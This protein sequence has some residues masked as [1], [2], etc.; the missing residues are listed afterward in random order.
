LLTHDSGFSCS[1]RSRCVVFARHGA[2]Q[3]LERAGCCAKRRSVH[4]SGCVDS[5]WYAY[6]VADKKIKSGY[7]KSHKTNLSGNDGR[8]TKFDNPRPGTYNCTSC[9]ECQVDYCHHLPGSETMTFT[10]AAGYF[11]CRVPILGLTS[12]AISRSTQSCCTAKPIYG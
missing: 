11:I 1:L 10:L 7:C 3:Q 6:A 8:A 2:L 4:N 12:I 9:S 5:F